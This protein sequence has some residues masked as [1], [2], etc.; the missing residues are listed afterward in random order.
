MVATVLIYGHIRISDLSVSRAG[1][2]CHRR[3]HFREGARANSRNVGTRARPGLSR[4]PRSPAPGSSQVWR[5]IAAVGSPRDVRAGWFVGFLRPHP[6]CRP[7]RLFRTSLG[8]KATVDYRQFRQIASAASLLRHGTHNS[9]GRRSLEWTLGHFVTY[10]V[11]AIGPGT[12]RFSNLREG[13]V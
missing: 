2:R 4:E 13:G 5:Q 6:T 1:H 9:G 11:L 7:T 10:I 12:A 3:H 8:Q